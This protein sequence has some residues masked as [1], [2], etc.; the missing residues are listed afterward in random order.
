MGIFG[1]SSVIQ[2]LAVSD[3]SLQAQVPLTNGRLEWL[4]IIIWTVTLILQF[5]LVM[6]CSK[7][8]LEYVLPI[9]NEHISIAIIEGIVIFGAYV[10]YFSFAKGIR[11]ILSPYF[12]YSSL[13]IQVV[14]PIILWIASCRLNNKNSINQSG[15][16]KE[17]G[18]E[19]IVE[20]SH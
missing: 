3:I 8:C 7:L 13:F 6:M 17:G 18:Y 1:K 9:K 20:N 11:I 10:L 5:L 16:L 2:T 12:Y 4:N 15:K 14:V 19:K